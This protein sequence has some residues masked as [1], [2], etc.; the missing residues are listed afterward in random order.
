[1]SKNKPSPEEIERAQYQRLHLIYT[2]A[3]IRRLLKAHVAEIKSGDG[4]YDEV[5]LKYKD[6][7]RLANK[8]IREY[9]RFLDEYGVYHRN[10]HTEEDLEWTSDC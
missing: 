10:S 1:M 5:Y 3:I 8:L 7:L 4:I 9:D 2:R 6:D